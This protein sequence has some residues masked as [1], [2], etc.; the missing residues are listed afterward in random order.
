MSLTDADWAEA[1]GNDTLGPHYYASRRFCREATESFTSEMMEP[2][3]KE[4]AEAFQHKLWDH[5]H[6]YLWMD[7]EFNLQGHMWRTV[8]DIVK[9]LLG[10]NEWALKKYVLGERY[11]CES[12]RAEVAKHI[13]EE[14]QA[15]E[16]K[17]LK[18]KVERLEEQNQFYRERYL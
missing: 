16:I 15:A 7:T 14:L 12:V 17:D 3:I 8:D 6:D 4:A 18:A 11:D 13:P 5:V 9:A 10:G 1:E 2:L